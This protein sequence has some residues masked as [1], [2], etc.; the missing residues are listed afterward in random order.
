MFDALTTTVVRVELPA[1]SRAASSAAAADSPKLT[2]H[3]GAAH[4][5]CDAS[6]IV[7]IAAAIIVVV[8]MAGRDAVL[9][10]QQQRKNLHAQAGS[11]E[12]VLPRSRGPARGTC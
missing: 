6:K 4:A 11:L 1:G 5:N 10:A 8:A 7:S 9:P 2:C 3:W 12:N